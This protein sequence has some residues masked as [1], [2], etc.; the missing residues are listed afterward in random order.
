MRK[1]M[2]HLKPCPFCGA[3]PWMLPD[4]ETSRVRIACTNSKCRV[5]PQTRGHSN[6]LVIKAWERR[7]E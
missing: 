1:R 5:R 7:A 3:V 2:P 4:G 6:L